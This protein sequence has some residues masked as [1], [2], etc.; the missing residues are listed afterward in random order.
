MLLYEY[1][2]KRW[3]INTTYIVRMC[4]QPS[5]SN[6]YPTTGYILVISMRD[7]DVCKFHYETKEEAEEAAN[8]IN[9][10]EE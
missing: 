4:I 3:Y 7:G 8:Y 9:A 6:D 10:G 5:S 1:K 2:N